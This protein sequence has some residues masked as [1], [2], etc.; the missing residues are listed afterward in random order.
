MRNLPFLKPADGAA[1]L[2]LLMAIGATG[3]GREPSA[4]SDA[5]APAGNSM[6]EATVRSGDVTIRASVL[7]TTAMSEV[8]AAQYGIQR[9]PGSVM[10]LVGVRQGPDMQ[11]TALPATITATATDLRGVRQTLELREVRSGDLVDYVGIARVSPPDTLRFDLDIR[12]E[13][14]ASSTM[15]FTRDIFPR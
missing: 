1:A 15:Q 3:C 12:R 14:G 2:A 4:M 13:D 9:D 6:Q 5:A 11:E 8:V 10:L 7:P